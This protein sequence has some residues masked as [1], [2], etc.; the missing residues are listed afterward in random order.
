[1]KRFFSV[2]T[3]LFCL[4]VLFA[5][6]APV[7]VD[8]FYSFADSTTVD[9][10]N[11]LAND[12]ASQN[13]SLHVGAIFSVSADNNLGSVDVNPLTHVVTFTRNEKSCGNEEF[14]YLLCDSQRCDT[15]N[16]TIVITCPDEVFLPRG[17]SPNGDGKNDK[18]VFTKLE[19]FTPAWLRVYNRYGSLVYDNSDYQN[20]WDGTE[21]DSHKALPDGTY[22]Y[23][24]QLS[25]K[26][27]YNSYVIINR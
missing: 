19:N 12:T 22:F 15:G 14:Q 3:S 8:D 17:F 27:S 23:I 11:I 20:D 18:L 7:A 5:Q 2:C 4:Q 13:D 6:N 26:H 25:D 1:M 10:L 9:T 16:I 21:M 24:L